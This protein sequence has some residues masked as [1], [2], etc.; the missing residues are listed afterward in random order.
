MGFFRQEYWSGL[1]FPSPGDLPDPGSN[2]HLLGLLHWRWIV[3]LLNH[4]VKFYGFTNAE[5]HVSTITISESFPD[6][7]LS[8][9]ICLFNLPKLMA[10]TDLFTVVFTSL[11]RA[12]VLLLPGTSLVAQMVKSLPAMWETCIRFLSWEDALEKEMVIHSS[13]LAWRIPRSEKLSDMVMVDT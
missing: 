9:L 8:S 5:H 7:K 12:V 11:S 13:V 2:P 6:L 3:Y 1:P 4:W 10:T